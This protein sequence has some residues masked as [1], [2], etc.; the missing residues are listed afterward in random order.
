VNDATAWAMDG[1]HALISFGHGFESV[2][3]PAAALLG[4]GVAFSWLA[5][6]KLRTI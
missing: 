3:I 5:A 1:L 6:R 2:V 4:F